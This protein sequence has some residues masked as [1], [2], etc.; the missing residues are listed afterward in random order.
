[1]NVVEQLRT[2]KVTSIST[3]FVITL[4]FLVIVQMFIQYAYSIP[5]S[6][7]PHFKIEDVISASF[8]P[9]TMAF[10][11]RDD[12]LILDRDAGKVFRVINGKMLQQP[13][14]DVNVATVGYRGML[15]IA[16]STDLN[17]RTSVFLYYTEAHKDREDEN[18]SHPVE[19]IGNRV[20]RYDLLD[21]R[22]VNPK[23]LLNLPAMP[24]PRHMGGVIAIGPDNNLYVSVGDLDGTFRGK[25]YDTM[26][27]NYLNSNILDG[28][29]G[30]LRM[31][32]DGKRVGEGILGSTFPLNLYY[33]YGIR[34][35]FGFDWDPLTGKLWDTEN[36]PHYGDEI[37]VV[38][39][40]FNSGWVKV[41]GAWEPN[42][43]QMGKITHDLK[44]VSFNGKGKYSEPE[45]TWIPTVAP[46]ALVFFNSSNYGVKYKNTL[47]VGDANTGTLY[48]FK[49]NI[50]RSGLELDGDLKD[51]IANNENEV[52]NVTFSTGFGR[53]TDMD[54]GLDGNLYVLSSKNGLTVHKIITH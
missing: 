46:T 30:I 24:G 29:S 17:N 27:Q 6:A 25:K 43:E 15:G 14:I 36:G 45:F 32:Q 40:G 38:E 9:S 28:R 21:N 1:M 3:G 42:F 54:L 23:L 12:F 48:N 7:N 49:L 13:V 18:L 5:L 52:K 22:L 8:K 11:G 31:N 2:S 47:F 37:N 20:Y 34:N 33:A 4:S 10:L 44:L 16:V 35:S 19:P 51:K 39:P 26:A 53:I 50:N 41:Q